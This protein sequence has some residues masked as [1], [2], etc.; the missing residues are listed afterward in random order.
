MRILFYK[1]DLAWPRSSGPDVHGFNMMRAMG[2]LGARIALVTLRTAQSNA[3]SGLDLDLLEPLEAAPS[4]NGCPSPLSGLAER[5]RSYWGVH[6]GHIRTLGLI[7]ERFRADAVVAI[8]LEVLPMLGAVRSACRIWYAA[9]EWW[10]HHLSQVRL[11]D[12]LT[13]MNLREAA[14]KGLYE[15]AFR[16]R[17]D[18]VWVVS[19]K[20]ARVMRWIAGMRAVDVVPNG[21]DSD[22]YQPLD[23]P[24]DPLTAT[25]WGR[26]DFG[27]NLQALSWFCQRVWP[28]VRRAHP[29]AR[30]TIIGFNP[31]PDA[32]ALASIPGVTV[33]PNVEDI[34][35]EVA[36]QAIVVMP[37]ISGGGI[38]NKLLEAAAL[39]KATVCSP[40]ALRGLNGKPPMIIAERTDDW[41]QSLHALWFDAPR[42]REIGRCLRSWVID[43]HGWDRPARSAL[44]ALA[45]IVRVH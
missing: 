7:A 41:L 37:F 20:E 32:W 29:D 16:D 18:R 8:G 27:P 14:V 10:W 9:D 38:K 26:L 23:V 35:S 3:L 40:R 42:R 28:A 24:E 6:A 34:R 33:R 1:A 4:D 30:F 39:G 43:E 2:R 31:A 13:W 17:I 22:W 15:R 19:A 11:T 12:P 36:R 5:Y 44:S 25:F 21:V 45:S